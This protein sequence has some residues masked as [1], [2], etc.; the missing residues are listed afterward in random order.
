[1][2]RKTKPLPLPPPYSP[3][4]QAA[5]NK[6]LDILSRRVRDSAVALTDPTAAGHYAQLRLGTREQEVFACIWLD[7]RHRVIECD[8]M[9]YGTVDGSEVHPREVVRRALQR[10]AAAVIF[11]HNH[12]SGSL[13]P[14]TAD[15]AVTVRLKEALRLIDVRV[16]DH[17]IVSESGFTS[18]ARLG[19]I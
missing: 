6:A 2:P 12:P 18:M 9:F 11:A 5:I 16:L 8:E 19:Q 4:E 14:S 17:F 10:N 15:R 13:D 7:A 3:D 1:M